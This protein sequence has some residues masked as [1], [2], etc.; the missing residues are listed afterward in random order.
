M[1]ILDN[2]NNTVRD[3]LRVEIKRGSKVSIAETAGAAGEADHRS[4]GKNEERKAAKS[5]DGAEGRNQETSIK[6]GGK[7]TWTKCVWNPLT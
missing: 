6:T 2:V 4:G 1:K 5:E 3:D 7:L